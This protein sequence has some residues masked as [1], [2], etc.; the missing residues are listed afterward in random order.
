MPIGPPQVLTRPAGTAP[1]GS[2]PGNEGNLDDE[3]IHGAPAPGPP[4]RGPFDCTGLSGPRS[5]AVRHRGAA[6]RRTCRAVIPGLRCPPAVTT[7]QAHPPRTSPRPGNETRTVSAQPSGSAR[8]RSRRADPRPRNW[9]C[10]T[11]LGALFLAAVI[12]PSA[13]PGTCTPAAATDIEAKALGIAAS[14]QG[15][16]YRWGAVGPERFDCS[17]L[18][19]YAFRKAGKSLPRTAQEQYNQ[20]PYIAR[21]RRH[22]GD[23]VFFHHG[24]HVYHVGIYAGDGEIWNAPHRGSY[25]RRER[26]WTA[27]VSYGRVP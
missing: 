14:K 8:R 3:G 23:L 5:I 27:A 7:R 9:C 24:N 18:T 12:G 26:I 1:V 6:A 16:P 11:A 17:G 15:D 2:P 25:V 19:F 22:P 13:L 21:S 4:T 20:V 10:R